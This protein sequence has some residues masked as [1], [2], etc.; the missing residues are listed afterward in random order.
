[1]ATSE[2]RSPLVRGGRVVRAGAVRA[3]RGGS[4]LADARN[5]CRPGPNVPVKCYAGDGLIKSSPNKEK[6]AA[7][8][9]E[10]T[11]RHIAPA[12]ALNVWS[13]FGKEGQAPGRCR[14]A[15]HFEGELRPGASPLFLFRVQRKRYAL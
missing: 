9:A 11:L 7:A 5:G 13:A 6:I 2:A 14:R 4:G 12:R 3:G 15:A 8:V 1:V 10:R